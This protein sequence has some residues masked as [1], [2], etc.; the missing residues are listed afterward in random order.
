MG[1]SGDASMVDNMLDIVLA[2]ALHA[3]QHHGCG[4]KADGAVGGVRDHA[5]GLFNQVER[6]EVGFVVEDALEQ[7]GQLTE[8]DAAGDTFAA[9][10][11]VAQAQERK[12]HVNRAKPRGTGCN[13]VFHVPVQTLDDGLRLAGRFDIQSAHG[14][15]PPCA[16]RVR[17]A[18]LIFRQSNILQVLRL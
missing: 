2:E 6:A 18:V 10:L 12:C 4:L 14:L 16:D 8:T 1:Q 5:C 15:I 7:R 13:A 11:C 9:G 3:A 17:S